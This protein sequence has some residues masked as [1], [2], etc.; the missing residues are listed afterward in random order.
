MRTEKN[1]SVKDFNKTDFLL[2]LE[3]IHCYTVAF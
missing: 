2:K 1:E 3:R